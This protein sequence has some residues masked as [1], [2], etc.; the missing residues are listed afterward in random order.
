MLTINAM[1]A[2]ESFLPP[3]YL[4]IEFIVSFSR[5]KEK[6]IRVASRDPKP[7]WENAIR[8]SSEDGIVGKLQDR[9]VWR[10]DVVEDM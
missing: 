2:L 8:L 7:A 1:L 10:R 5:P 4:T 9:P 3:R 6:L